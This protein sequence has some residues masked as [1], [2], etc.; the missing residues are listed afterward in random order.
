L[1]GVL[2]RAAFILAV[3]EEAALEASGDGGGG[4]F[5]VF[6]LEEC[7]VAENGLEE[8]VVDHSC[9]FANWPE[10][11]AVVVIGSFLSHP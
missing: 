9:S 10:R 7:E 3:A 11:R 2:T 6:L 4:L 1:S 5:G 8:V